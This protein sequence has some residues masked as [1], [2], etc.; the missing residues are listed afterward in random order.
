MRP[1]SL[2]RPFLFLLAIAFSLVVT[3]TVRFT[4]T[5]WGI[6]AQGSDQTKS[7]RATSRLNHELRNGIAEQVSLMR[8]QFS[9]I[10]KSFPE[11]FASL[12]YS[13]GQLQTEYLKL[14]IDM[15]ER[16][17]VE[18]IKLLQAELGIEGLQ[19]FELLEAGEDVAAKNGL[20]MVENLQ[21]QI[22]DGFEDLH[23]VQMDKLQAVQTE[24]D[25]SVSTAFISIYVLAANLVFALAIFITLLRKRVV[26]PIKSIHEATIQ[27]RNGDF[28]A[29]A[30]V[31]RLDEIGQVG[32]CFN[33]MAESLAQS[34][35]DLERTIEDRTRQVHQLQQE[36]VQAAKMS[37][38][39]QMISGVAHELN[40]P[41]TVIMGYT[42]L[43]RMRLS[44]ARRDPTEVKLMEE[45]YA[46][47]DRCRKIVANLLQFAR[48]ATPEIELIWINDLIEKVMQLREYEFQTRNVNFVREFDP[49]NPSL[50]ADRNGLQQVLL[51]LINNAYDAIRDTGKAGSIWVETVAQ[52]G[53]VT[54][55]VRDS[56]PG[57]HE[58]DRVF[59]PFYTTKDVGKGTGLGLSVCYGIIEEHKGEIRAG[60]W[61]K[62]AR[63]R[64]TL[65]I[66]GPA[67]ATSTQAKTEQAIAVKDGY[68]ALVV[69]DECSIVNLQ[70]A[71]LSS[72]G[73]EVFG[74][75]SG[76]EAMSFLEKS[77]VD[78][79]ISD[80]RMPGAVD[81]IGLF[82]WLQR[83]K[84]ELTDRFVFVTGDSVGVTTG[85]LLND[86]IVPH[87]EKPF[88]FDVYSQVVRGILEG[89][90]IVA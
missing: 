5:I 22:Q 16:L 83:E 25:R 60:N 38:V 74:A 29:R 19:S 2:S 40:N 18:R 64:V 72:I 15:Q 75:A 58:L 53:R 78:I 14:D 90:R 85:E 66:G 43:S 79:V 44:A 49:A 24:L 47:A 23:N 86:Q 65:P 59:E 50:Y 28:S 80:I 69:D 10:E 52:E 31:G 20:L 37:A 48:K 46:Q 11:K 26:S 39:G 51:N 8:D 62:G 42:E 21:K 84:P 61:E 9:S 54:I 13:I 73:I 1:T 55:E 63:F 12:D 3:F 32:Q 87:I 27:V 4:Y 34:Y 7:I 36:F 89:E 76:E 56:G 17:A 33:F 70:S 45:L 68:S 57:I 71:Y 88:R 77:D 35:S 67:D 30:A 81:G 41:L 6:S 82:K